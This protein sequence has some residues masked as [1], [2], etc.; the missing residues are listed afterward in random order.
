MTLERRLQNYMKKTNKKINKKAFSKAEFM[1]MLA[2]I[3]ILIAIGSKLVL[4]N[5]KNY[6]SYN[7]FFNVYSYVFCG[8]M[9]LAYKCDFKTV[10]TFFKIEKNK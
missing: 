7:S 4:D 5:T 9:T 8:V 6:S 3:A 2:A 10:L 1:V